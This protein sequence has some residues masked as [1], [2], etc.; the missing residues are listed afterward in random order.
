MSS[1]AGAS[2]AAG[3]APSAEL[4]FD[5][6]FA[7]QK[8]AALK[9][10]VDLDVF[11]A[12]HEGA[13]TPAAI[14]QRCGGTERGL[15]ILCDYLT[16]LGFLTKG[17]DGYRVTTDTATFLSKQ[18]PAY[19]GGTLQFF[20][21]PE[22]LRNFSVLADTIRRGSVSTEGNTVADANPIWVEFARAMV[23]MMVPAAQVIAD[24][25][26]V[27]AAGPIRVLDIAAGHGVFGITIA[28]RNPLAEVVAVDWA[29]VLTVAT[30]NATAMGVASRHHTLPGDAFKVDYGTGF[31]VALLTNFLHH[32]DRDT[33]VT[34]L[35]KVANA[36]NTGGRVVVLEMVPDENRIS[37]PFPA[38][39]ALTM[40]AGTPAGDAY[41]LNEL[42]EMLTAAGFG[43]ATAHPTPTPETVVVATRLS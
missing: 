41:T 39:F 13:H 28:Q 37:P 24:A 12:I 27:A 8:T 17:A 11:T 33:N 3:P 20:G 25:L 16:V 7:H 35:R 15:R 30:E 19:L 6:A 1:Q 32:F 26:G 9:A 4:F 2:A 14:A 21:T 42:Q 36:L 31:D 22:L 5:T 23:P 18:S 29:A 38:G 34:L 40:L 43:R 10:A